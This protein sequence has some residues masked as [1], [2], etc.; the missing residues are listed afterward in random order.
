[1]NI[2]RRLTQSIFM[3]A[4]PRKGQA[5]FALL[6]AV[7]ISLLCLML[8][9][10]AVL[11]PGA[12]LN[13]VL[14]APRMPKATQA[15][16]L[17]LQLVVAYP[18][19]G[20]DIATDRIAGLLHG[21]EIRYLDSAKWAAFVPDFMQRLLVDSLEASKAFSGVGNSESGLSGQVMLSMDIRR[22]YLRYDGADKPPMAD[23]SL[24][25]RLVDLRTGT[26]LGNTTI[27]AAVISTGESTRELVEAVNQALSEALAKNSAWVLSMLDP[28]AK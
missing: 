15:P 11:D 5:L 12:P 26:A 23:I 25:M 14:L 13:Q 3:P 7:P 8:S 10:C 21:Y 4:A 1:M 24:H 18:T 16:P 20:N 28:A 22:F 17:P 6:R 27:D 19:A 2:L 9:A